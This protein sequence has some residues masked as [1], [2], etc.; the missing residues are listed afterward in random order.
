MIPILPVWLVRIVCLVWT[1]ACL[2]S[3]VTDISSWVDRLE[4]LD[5][6]RPLEYFELAE[7][8]AD[9]GT[10]PEE[11]LLALELFALAGQLDFDQLGQSSILAIGYFST[12]PIQKERLQIA[13]NLLSKERLFQGRDQQS[14]FSSQE[15][16]FR[17]GQMLGAVRSGEIQRARELLKSPGVRSLLFEYGDLLGLDPVDFLE[18]LESRSP[19]GISSEL[20]RQLLV[21][22]TVLDRPGLNWSAELLASGGA[23]LTIIDIVD[24]G[25][26]LGA[27]ADRPYWRGGGWSQRPLSLD[28]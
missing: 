25:A 27:D 22:W 15:D 24:L 28:Q 12:D 20:T 9:T 7:E 18:K 1:P 8:I 23:P 5:P 13:A 3:P 14:S 4:Q 19:I 10:T 11:R 2:V 17:F 21:E 6:S 26:L 16:Q